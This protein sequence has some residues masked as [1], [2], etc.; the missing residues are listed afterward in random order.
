M[1]T[2]TTRAT[3]NL[4]DLMDELASGPSNLVARET[5]H[6]I[7][8]GCSSVNLLE[9]LEREPEGIAVAMDFP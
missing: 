7:E 5:G 3:Y 4:R 2:T 1:D 6:L 9:S 8:S